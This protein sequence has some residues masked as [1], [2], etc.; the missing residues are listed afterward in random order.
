MQTATVNEESDQINTSDLVESAKKRR[1]SA[2][3]TAQDKSPGF[4]PYQNDYGTMKAV[5]DDAVKSS[6][7]P[8]S[9]ALLAVGNFLGGGRSMVDS[10]ATQ[11]L[12]VAQEQLVEQKSM[13]EQL[14]AIKEQG[15]ANA[16]S[17]GIEIGNY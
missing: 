7:M 17:G 13:N 14:K 8:A 5:K 10:I 9:D 6:L 1:A 4:S 3:K 15:V 12:A 2:K 11:Q 16:G